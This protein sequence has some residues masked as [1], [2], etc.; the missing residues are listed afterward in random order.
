FLL[1]YGVR[2][3]FEKT[4]VKIMKT[5]GIVKKKLTEETSDLTTEETSNSSTATFFPSPLPGFCHGLGRS[6]S[7]AIPGLPP[8]QRR[9][10]RSCIGNKKLRA[11]RKLDCEDSGKISF[12][13]RCI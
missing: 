11:R 13:F 1:R 9:K 5:K 2:C 3:N 8:S 4:S 7:S 10:C 6:E 12:Q